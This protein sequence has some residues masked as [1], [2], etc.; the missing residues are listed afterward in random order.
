MTTTTIDGPRLTAAQHNGIAYEAG[1]RSIPGTAEY[2]TM[3]ARLAALVFLGATYG[4]QYDGGPWGQFA[5]SLCRAIG[6][7][8]PCAAGDACP[9]RDAHRQR[10]DGTDPAYTH[11]PWCGDLR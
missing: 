6:E 11:G 8:A 2:L 9:D 7:L 4:V 3:R 5:V 1:K 10:N